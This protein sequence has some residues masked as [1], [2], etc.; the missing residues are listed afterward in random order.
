MEDRDAED[1]T[2][3]GLLLSGKYLSGI[4]VIRRLSR[5][6]IMYGWAEENLSK[7]NWII[8]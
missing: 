4:S 6:S 7:Y 8:P 3:S 1:V 5:E 2:T